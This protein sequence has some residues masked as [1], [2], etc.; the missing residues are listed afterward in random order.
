LAEE[1]GVGSRLRLVGFI[2][3]VESVYGAAEVIA[4]PS[5]E[6]DP[7]AGV[8]I[9]AAAAGCAVV[10]SGHGGL[11]EIIRDGI[12]GCLVA[13]G[14][15]GGLARAARELIDDPDW[16]ERLGAAAVSDVGTRFSPE[17]LLGAIQGLYDE[18][19]ERRER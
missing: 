13:P 7:L 14:D 18:L 15:P 2:D 11:V 1:L 19:L 12:T 3:D 4:V 16:R 8:A 9:E 6:P 10:A 17:R 5:T